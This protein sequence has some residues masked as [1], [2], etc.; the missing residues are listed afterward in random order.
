MDSHELNELFENVVD[1]DSWGALIAEVMS[2]DLNDGGEVEVIQS[3]FSN[4]LDYNNDFR[5]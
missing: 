4:I 5:E 3:A 2:G 1:I